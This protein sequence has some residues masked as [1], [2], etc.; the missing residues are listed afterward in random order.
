[1]N[2]KQIKHYFLLPDFYFLP[3]L[4]GRNCSFQ[5]G[6]NMEKNKFFSALEETGQPWQLLRLLV[7]TL[8]SFC[9]SG[10]QKR[11]LSHFSSVAL[12]ASFSWVLK[13]PDFRWSFDIQKWEKVLAAALVKQ[14][15]IEL[16]IA[17]IALV[18]LLH[19]IKTKYLKKLKLFS[20]ILKEIY[21]PIVWLGKGNRCLPFFKSI[22]QCN[23]SWFCA[24]NIKLDNQE[25]V[26]L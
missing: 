14:K 12:Y 8:C 10:S 15:C 25:Q 2:F 16:W 7:A 5:A 9:D 17:H 26:I 23:A 22:S 3:N 18:S 24:K 11:S 20:I 1:M 19:W 6:K 21:E 4:C 13:T